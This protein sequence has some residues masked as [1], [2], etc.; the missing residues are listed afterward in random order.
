MT[1]VVGLRVFET[2]VGEKVDRTRPYDTILA[3][4]VDGAGEVFEVEPIAP[5]ADAPRESIEP[6]PRIP[7]ET[8][9]PGAPTHTT[10]PPATSATNESESES[11]EFIPSPP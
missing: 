8:W 2:T 7:L 5:P 3:P 4:T 6:L 9:S 10:E 11:E 1:M